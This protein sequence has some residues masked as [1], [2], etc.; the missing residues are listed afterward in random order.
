MVLCDSSSVNRWFWAGSWYFSAVLRGSGWLV[1][2]LHLL[3]PPASHF[4][5]NFCSEPVEKFYTQ[6][7]ISWSGPSHFSL[8]PPPHR[9]HPR[10]LHFLPPTSPAPLSVFLCQKCQRW[11]ICQSGVVLLW[12]SVTAGHTPPAARGSMI[13]QAG[14]ESKC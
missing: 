6:C 9:P 5:S 12:P 8:K 14:S 2:H 13:N 3:R 1:T 4:R 7:G 11:L 10:L